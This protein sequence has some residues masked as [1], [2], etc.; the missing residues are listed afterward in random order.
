[1]S[2]CPLTCN[3]TVLFFRAA[4]PVW[5]YFCPVRTFPI[6]SMLSLS[7]SLGQQKI[8][9]IFLVKS[10]SLGISCK[11]CQSVKVEL[12]TVVF[13]T[14]QKS[15]RKMQNCKRLWVSRSSDNQFSYHFLKNARNLI[16]WWHLTLPLGYMG[17]TWCT[18]LLYLKLL[19]R[20]PYLGHTFDASP[21]QMAERVAALICCSVKICC[22]VLKGM[23]RF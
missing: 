2:L 18:C 11:C 22:R 1:M 10:V 6:R 20:R 19:G 12:N 21:V 7:A 4:M 3:F 13:T 5:E 9:N 8:L 17:P 23:Y 15:Y 16:L 14:T